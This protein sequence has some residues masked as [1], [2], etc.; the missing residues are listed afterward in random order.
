MIDNVKMFVIDRHRLEDHINYNNLIN[1]NSKVNMI[2]GE[3]LEYPKKGKDMNLDV[4]VTSNAATILGSIHKYKNLLE[5]NGNQNHDDFNFRQIQEIIVGLLKKYN[6]E[7]D[8]KITNLEFGF[9]LVMSKDPKTVLDNNLLMNNFKAPNKNLKFSGSGDYK[10]FQLTDYRIKIYNKSKQYKLKSNILRVELKITATRLLQ[11]LAIKSLEDLLNKEVLTSLFQ[12]FME[13][14]EILNIID[15]FNP[16][17]IPEKDYNKL[18]KYTNPNFWIRVK[19]DK[20][21][22][23]IYKLKSDYNNLLNT[24]GLLVT[25]NE[26]REKLS[27]KFAELMDSDR[28]RNVA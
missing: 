12:I 6:I 15:N 28:Y 8:T 5:G 24:Y 3:V 7:K 27:L 20:S 17:T 25:K 2:T 11:Q 21:A 4:S 9:N 14:F 1:F 16:E 10:E 22:K 26:I 13:K 19:A 18:N 23:V